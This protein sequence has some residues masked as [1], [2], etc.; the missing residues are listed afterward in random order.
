LWYPQLLVHELI[1][2]WRWQWCI[3]CDHSTA[4][5]FNPE[6]SGFEEGF[7]QGVS[8]QVMNA[9]TST[10]GEGD[11]HVQFAYWLA[12]TEWDYDF[13]NDR[14]MTTENYWSEGG[15]TQKFFERYEMGAAAIIKIGINT[16]NFAKD[17]NRA[18]YF[19][20]KQYI[21][22]GDPNHVFTRQEIIDI[23]ELVSPTVEGKP[24]EEWINDQ[25][26]FD[27]EYEH[28]KK[29]WFWKG[30]FNLANPV[31]IIQFV[32]TFPSGTEWAHYIQALGDYLYHR[33]NG[34]LGNM[35]FVQA[36]NNVI[37]ASHQVE[38]ERPSWWPPPP[39]CGGVGC[40]YDIGIGY[41]QIEVYQTNPSQIPYIQTPIQFQQ[42]TTKG[43]YRFDVSFNN[44]HY[45]A[46]PNQPLYGITYDGTQQSAE[47]EKHTLLGLTAQE[48][49]KRIIGGIV[50]AQNGSVTVS[51][52]KVAG[53][54][55]IC[56][57]TNG[58]FMCAGQPEWYGLILNGSYPATKLG[59][60]KFVFIPEGSV[61]S[62]EARRIVD[63][64]FA[65][66]HQFLLDINDMIPL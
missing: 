33:L 42:P 15:G 63:I 65:S 37:L 7:A 12:D 64:G 27:Q 56:Q 17:F 5:I 28:G 54:S 32:E 61:Q 22:G 36:W 48:Y 10:Y 23:M 24:L 59:T 51:H 52:N 66:R 2:A 26:I 41:D 20:T 50:G 31:Y 34:T 55:D 14:S 57:V 9:Y 58:L 25:R 4:Y 35:D 49:D 47:D 40:S 46:P 1:H 43:L 8:Y 62:Y 3:T 19:I 13:R 6:L 44:P 53:V 29:V 16:P 45:V 21:D 39:P 11:P 60:F 38:M 30:Y 18:Y